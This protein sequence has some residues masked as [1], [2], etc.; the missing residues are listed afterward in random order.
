MEGAQRMK[1]RLEGLAVST[2]KELRRSVLEVA[3]R[4]LPLLRENTPMKT[5]KL[6]ASERVRVMV[7]A[8]REDIRVSLIAGDEEAWY[9][10]IVEFK[11][12]YMEKTILDLS[13]RVA[14]EIA[15]EFDMR[16]AARGGA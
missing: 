15:A 7:S 10:R 9:A 2:P 3:N 5:G 8:K 14:G 12:H 13:S 11:K 6:R 1:N 4:N 16:Q